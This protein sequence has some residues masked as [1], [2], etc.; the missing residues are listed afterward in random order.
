V[1]KSVNKLWNSELRECDFDVQQHVV[2]C[3]HLL[4]VVFEMYNA[5]YNLP[6][7]LSRMVCSGVLDFSV[8]ANL[9]VRT[10]DETTERC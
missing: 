7:L 2:R 6:C 8:G 5:Y 1:A 3:S 4:S 10:V 9:A